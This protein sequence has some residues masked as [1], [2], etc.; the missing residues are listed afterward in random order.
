MKVL[1]IR[2]GADLAGCSYALKQA[3]T[4]FSD[5]RVSSVVRK[6]NY[7]DYPHDKP[8]SEAETLY[9]EADVVHLHENARPYRM[10]GH[11]PF[12]MHLHGTK[13]RRFSD[14]FNRFIRDNAGVGV[15]ATL[16]LLDYG[17]NLTWIPHPVLGLKR[18]GFG[19]RDESRP[20]RVAHAPTSRD[21]KG[22]NDFLDACKKTGVEPVL[23]ERKTNAECIQIKETCDALYD[24]MGLGY[25]VN[26]IEAWAMGLP[27]IAG[28]GE[29][30]LARMHD[31]FGGLPFMQATPHTLADALASL[32][33][34]GAY[35]EASTR[36]YDHY[37][38]WHNGEETAKRLERTY[39]RA[40]RGGVD[41]R[42]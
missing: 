8:W 34:P 5:I 29:G 15:V 33:D 38:R 27:V 22:T 41:P 9:R 36:G 14:E 4:A 26:A 18:V 12:V 16:D 31:T 6:T 3:M 42:A 37:R 13:Y 23:I 11:K 19:D 2:S 17:T 30:T 20:L 25:G 21:V 24:Q 39:T 10:W 7:L 28:A 1:S 40:L 32:G 35:W